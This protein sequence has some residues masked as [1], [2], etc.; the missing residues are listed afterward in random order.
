MT[1]LVEGIGRFVITV[2]EDAGRTGILLLKSVATLRRP[3]YYLHTCFEQM[4]E[5]IGRDKVLGV[6]L[7]QSGM[8]RHSRYYGYYGYEATPDAQEEPAR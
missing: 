8:P 6:F 4:L 5:V 1:G 3:P 2:L 7:N